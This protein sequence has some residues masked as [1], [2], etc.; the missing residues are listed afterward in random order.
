MLRE[1]FFSV[2]KVTTDTNNHNYCMNKHI[3][4]YTFNMCYRIYLKLTE[5]NGIGMP[6]ANISNSYIMGC[7]PVRGDNPRALAS[8]L[9]YVQ[10]YKH[11]ITFYTTY[12]SADLA[13][14]EIFRA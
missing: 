9:S 10:M 6:N 2:H 5:I 3:W 4:P 7:P 8:G 13:H 11:D 12:V 1:I 14:H